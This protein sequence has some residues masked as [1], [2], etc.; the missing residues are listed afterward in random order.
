[1]FAGNAAAFPRVEHLK[2]APVLGMLLAL[3]K[4]IRLGWRGL[5]G[6]NTPAYYD[7]SQITASKS[8]KNGPCQIVHSISLLMSL[9]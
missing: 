4:N 6:T 3:P 2:C 8:L 9:Y 1:M 7:H 5:P